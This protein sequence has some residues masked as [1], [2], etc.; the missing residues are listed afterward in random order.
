MSQVILLR[1]I[2]DITDVRCMDDM[3]CEG[4]AARIALEICEPITQDLGKAQKCAAEYNRI[5][6]EA[7]IVNAIESGS[8][9]PPEDD[10]ISCRA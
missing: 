7:R 5:M 2:A 6:G 9:Q 8:D 4:L 1:F 10:Y 3:F